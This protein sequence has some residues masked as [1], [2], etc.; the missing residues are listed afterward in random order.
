MPATDALNI[1]LVDDEPGRAAILKE[2]L[3]S[4]GHQV[5][6][7]SR[8]TSS[9]YQMVNAFS[10]DVIIVDTKAPDRDVLEDLALVS[11]KNPKP[12]LVVSE[13]DDEGIIEQAIKAGASAYVVDGLTEGRLRGVLRTAIA[14]FNEYQALKSELLSARSELQ[15]RKVIEKAK[16]L[17]MK[18]KGI[19]E[20]ESYTTLRN[21]AMQK[22]RPLRD[23]A[24]DIVELFS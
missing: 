24:S 10:P 9:I 4:H 5:I 14:R 21:L 3:Q 18:H 23:V 17:L 12:V 7:R 19:D 22:N 11:D 1:M 6:Y 15:D 16:G 20:N 13:H 2:A 8:T